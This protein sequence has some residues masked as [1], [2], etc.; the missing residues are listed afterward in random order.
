MY[1]GDIRL[2]ETHDFKFPTRRFSTGA[3]FTLAGSPVISA[4]VGNGTTEITAGIT[5][6]VDFDG[7]TGLN[8]V[9]VVATSGNGFAAGTDVDLVI[10]TGTVDGVSVVGE[11]VAS[12]SIEN[13]SALMPATAG[14]TLVVDAA[15]LADANMVKAGPSGSGT[16][17]TAGDIIGDTNDIQSRLPAALGANGNIKADVRDYNG[18]AGAFSGGRPEVNTSHWGGTAVASA[19]VLIDGAITAAKIASDAITAAKVQDG[20]LTA[21]KFASGAFDAVWSVATRLLT[22]GTNIVLAKGVGVTGFNDLSAA[23]VNAEAD[24][25]LADYDAPTR[26]ELTSDTN[27][28]LSKLLKYVQLILRK[29]AAIGTDNATE[30]TAINADGGSGAGAF[31]QTT[32]S[33][34]ALRDNQQPAA[35]AALTAYDPP[36]RTEATADKDEILAAIPSAAAVADQ[37]WEEQIG[38]HDGTAGSTAEQLSA[39]GAAGDP[40]AT[41]LPGAYSAGQA[42]KIVGDN[43]NATVGSRASQASVDDVPTNAELATA[44]AAADDAVLAAIAALN[45]LSQANIRTAIGL[46]SANLD[47]QLLAIAAF[48]DTEVAAIKAKTD[49]LPSDPADASDIAASFASIAST[50]SGLATQISVDDLPTNSELSTALAAADDAVLAAIAALS[51]PTAAQNAAALL[52]LVDGV[53]TGLTPRQALRLMT[54]ALAGKISGAGTTTIVIRNAVADSK[55]RITATVDSNGNRSAIT[56]DMS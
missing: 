56:A 23:Q 51:V 31:D 15:G 29:D 40:W 43:L 45:N 27:S 28:I 12:F 42:G 3:P 48:I 53:E 52:D 16:A 14:R 33:Q 20:F 50:L 47:T 5:L 39:A 54:A 1:Q 6:T 55:D 35:A 25:A 38:D 49:N 46:G 22:A 10:T 9:R 19:N 8:N 34:E 2:G 26:A 7:R 36:T 17:Q 32:D 4:Y 24:T 41:A 30:K 21:A 13:R 37:V 44:L 18:V 11:V